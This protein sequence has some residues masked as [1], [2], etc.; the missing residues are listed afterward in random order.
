LDNFLK[1]SP[2]KWKFWTVCPNL[3]IDPSSRTP[4]HSHHSVKCLI[5]PYVRTKWEISIRERS[6][7]VIS[8][9]DEFLGLQESPLPDGKARQSPDSENF[10]F[11]RSHLEGRRHFSMR[12]RK[13]PFLLRDLVSVRHIPKSVILLYFG[14]LKFELRVMQA[15]YSAPKIRNSKTGTRSLLIIEGAHPDDEQ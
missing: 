5:C 3:E 4:S 9:Q 15:D 12:S 8:A 2:L 10:P 11:S 6:G 7:R 14:G 1:F 13:L